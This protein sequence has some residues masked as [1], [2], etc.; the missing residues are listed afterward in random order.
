MNSHC[1]RQHQRNLDT[2]NVNC[3]PSRL[4]VCVIKESRH[5]R[6]RID[7]EDG[8]GGGGVFRA[9]IKFDERYA[10]R[11]TDLAGFKVGLDTFFRVWS[12]FPVIGKL[13]CSFKEFLEVAEDEAADDAA[14]AIDKAV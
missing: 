4:S 13:Y 1:P 12:E 7:G 9:C 11:S 6:I 2:V 5:Y 3:I 10:D 8:V 14:G